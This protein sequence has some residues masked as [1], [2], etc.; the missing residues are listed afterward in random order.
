M[1]LADYISRQIKYLDLDDYGNSW[2][3]ISEDLS[4]QIDRNTLG[5][6]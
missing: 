1:F 2:D 5:S 6:L 4:Q 3:V